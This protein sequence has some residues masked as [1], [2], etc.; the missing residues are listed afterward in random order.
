MKR[1]VLTA[2]ILLAPILALAQSEN[3]KEQ[4]FLDRFDK[5]SR[6]YSG[7]ILVTYTLCGDARHDAIATF[8]KVTTIIVFDRAR[9]SEDAKA[10]KQANVDKIIADV[11]KDAELCPAQ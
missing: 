7:R 10:Q 1:L 2:A 4:I 6:T 9:S 8:D 11:A 5:S 3:Y